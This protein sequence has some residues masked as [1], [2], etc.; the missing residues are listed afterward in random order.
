MIFGQQQQEDP[1]INIKKQELGLTKNINMIDLADRPD[2]EYMAR[3]EER[4][5]LTRWQQDLDE[6]LQKLRYNLMNYTFNF[7]KQTWGA[8]TQLVIDEDGNEKEVPIP[9]LLNK[10]GI[11]KT[12]SVVKQYLNRNVMMSN[13][14]LQIINRI[15]LGFSETLILDLGQNYDNYDPDRIRR[16]LPE[17]DLKLVLKLLQDTVEPTLYRAL[18]NGERK[19]L[20]TTHKHIEAFTDQQQPQKKGLFNRLGG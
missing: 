9:P 16:H 14:S 20:N 17:N 2:Q 6:D 8:E 3:K 5:D 7:E 1:I 15:M 18:D 4:D 19:Y 13:L 11:A 10:F 12:T